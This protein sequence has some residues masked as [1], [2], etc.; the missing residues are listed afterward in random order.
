MDDGSIGETNNF[1]LS[2][3]HCWTRAKVIIGLK[4]GLDLREAVKLF[5][6]GNDEMYIHKGNLTLHLQGS[7]LGVPYRINKGDKVEVVARGTGEEYVDHI[8]GLCAYL[9]SEGMKKDLV[10]VESGK[11]HKGGFVFW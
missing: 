11:S 1:N 6:Q 8:N 4:E 3:R 5:G 7:F 9:A 2:Q 10:T